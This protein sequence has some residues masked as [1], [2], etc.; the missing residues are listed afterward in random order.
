VDFQKEIDKIN[1]NKKAYGGR[2]GFAA[3]GID[4]ARRAFLKILGGGA[5]TGVAVKTGLGGLLKSGEKAK[6][7]AK[8]VKAAE[9]VKNAPPSYVFDLS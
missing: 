1:R 2:I 6:D 5:A 8:V 4:K 9:T 7:V 3:G